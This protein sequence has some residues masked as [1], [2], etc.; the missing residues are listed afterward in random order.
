MDK[1]RRVNILIDHNTFMLIDFLHKVIVF[2]DI[3]SS[4]SLTDFLE[5][6]K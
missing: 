1:K 6:V 3:G 4:S 5:E 2:F